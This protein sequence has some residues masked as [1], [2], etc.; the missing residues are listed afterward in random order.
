MAA[1]Y[2]NAVVTVGVDSYT[3]RDLMKTR[4]C[5]A[6]ND[7]DAELAL[8]LQT[9]GEAAESYTSNAVAKQQVINLATDWGRLV[10]LPYWPVNALNEVTID[11]EDV[12]ADWVLRLTYG[13]AYAEHV[14]G[15]TVV[16]GDQLSITYSAGYDPLPADLANALVSAAI[17]YREGGAAGGGVIR[18]ESV[19]GVG[20]VEYANETETYGAFTAAG[21]STLDRYRYWA[22]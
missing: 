3:L 19:V 10:R 11:G 8:H 7:Y 5:I 12:T 20:S 2:A 9:A 6:G 16:T 15:S 18:R 14:T 13:V 17:N 22:A 4:L 1:D 21:I